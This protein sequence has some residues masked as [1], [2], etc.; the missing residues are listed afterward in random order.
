[1]NSNLIDWLPLTP[2]HAPIATASEGRAPP[3]DERRDDKAQPGDGGR[4]Q[5]VEGAKR[6]QQQAASV[7]Q[8]RS[9][10]ANLAT[11]AEKHPRTSNSITPSGELV[12]PT[13]GALPAPP[14][15]VQ[16]NKSMQQARYLYS[17][18]TCNASALLASSHST[19]SSSQRAPSPSSTAPASQASTSAGPQSER[20]PKV[21]VS[22]PRATHVVPR[23]QAQFVDRQQR[24]ARVE[25]EQKRLRELELAT[26]SPVSAQVKIAAK[27]CPSQLQAAPN[28][29][30]H[31]SSSSSSSSDS[32]DSSNSDYD[33]DSHSPTLDAAAWKRKPEATSSQ[34]E[35]TRD[36]N[37]LSADEF[38]AAQTP[39]IVE[40][41]YEHLG[42]F[43]R[44][45]HGS[46]TSR[47]SSVNV[48]L[49]GVGP[50]QQLQ[51]TAM[52]P[53]MHAL[54][55][56]GADLDTGN[57]NFIMATRRRRSVH[58]VHQVQLAQIQQQQQQHQQQQ[59]QQQA[60]P[61]QL[62]GSK[63]FKID[64]RA[65]TI[66]GESTRATPGDAQTT[67]GA[68]SL[69]NELRKLRATCSIDE[70]PVATGKLP[71]SGPVS[72][73]TQAQSSASAKSARGASN[74]ELSESWAPSAPVPV[75]TCEQPEVLELEAPCS[76]T[77]DL[78]KREQ[79]QIGAQIV[80]GAHGVDEDR[81]GQTSDYNEDNKRFYQLHD[82]NY[83]LDDLES[84]STLLANLYDWNYPIFE[85]AE[86][87]GH[88]IL[89]KLSYRI[90]FD[91]GFFDCKL[92]S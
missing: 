11:A 84:S 88:S 16:D 34:P 82:T 14:S 86:Q 2:F 79:K 77:I 23:K 43:R 55:A 41:H 65:S 83:D 46:Q 76:P 62:Q 9:Q 74:A 60:Q 58:V 27:L 15:L 91:S 3:Q 53:A 70:V 25:R 24:K 35:P 29:P 31:S 72:K 39:A 33:S 49:T 47:S 78:L 66:S 89:S 90:F 87:Y 81:N 21:G 73:S 69:R 45:S 22:P 6:S 56:Q 48:E 8:S 32:S 1:M 42:G 59:Q 63:C 85:L 19:L 18:L 71:D 13:G 17:T 20:T 67:S 50:K 44:Q 52:D 64:E 92:Q 30:H 75:V 80:T 36:E 4:K 68:R 40:S 7:C 10:A 51:P 28:E 5:P 38:E 61:Q 12:G 26:A 57:G 54:W 37:S